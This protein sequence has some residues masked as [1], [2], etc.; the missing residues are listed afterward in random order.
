V[1]GEEGG[2]VRK[3]RGEGQ[4]EVERRKGEK[5]G[6]TE[7]NCAVDDGAGKRSGKGKEMISRVSDQEKGK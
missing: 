4:L 7:K 3:Q 1:E 6:R 2:E 5:R